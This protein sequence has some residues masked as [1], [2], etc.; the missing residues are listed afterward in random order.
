MAGQLYPPTD[1]RYRRQ[2]Q[3]GR[4]C[5]NPAAID[6]CQ[7]RAGVQHHD[8]DHLIAKPTALDAVVQQKILVLQEN[9]RQRNGGLVQRCCRITP[10]TGQWHRRLG[11][12]LFPAR[13]YHRLFLG[14]LQL[15]ESQADHHRE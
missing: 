6:Q 11:L 8:S 3:P 7:P 9:P 14:A 5:S 10:Y 12:A 4:V 15:P 2:R 1:C 13:L